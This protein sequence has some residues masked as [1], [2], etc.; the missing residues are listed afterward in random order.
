MLYL[1]IGI[2]EILSRESVSYLVRLLTESFSVDRRGSAVDS[3]IGDLIMSI[4]R[5]WVAIF[6]S[7][8]WPEGVASSRRCF[9]GWVLLRTI[10]MACNNSNIVTRYFPK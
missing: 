7:E 4:R 5:W 2:S 1:R 10:A 8:S 3:G 9:V 6:M